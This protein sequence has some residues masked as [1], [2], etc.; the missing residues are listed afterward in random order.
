[1]ST[2]IYFPDITPPAWP[3][4]E[5]AEDT[6]IISQFEDGSQQS[7]TAKTRSRRKWTLNWNNIPRKEYV[8]LMHFVKNIAKFSA[9]SFYWINTDSRDKEY[10]Y[11]NPYQEEVEVRIT[12][13]GKWSNTTDNSKTS[14]WSGSL[15]LTE[16]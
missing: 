9:N 14:F 1:M 13:V 3:F 2:K 10:K 16:V 8:I 15:E 5:E 12:G 6:S 11:L 4:D 7:R